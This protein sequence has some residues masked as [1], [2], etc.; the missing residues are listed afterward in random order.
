MVIPA[1]AHRLSHAEPS[2]VVLI[3]T[4]YYGS[5]RKA[6][7][8]FLAE[9]FAALGWHVTFM[10]VGISPISGLRGDLRLRY[11][12]RAEANRVITKA[13]GIDS[14]VWYT[15]WHPFHLR[16]PLLDTLSAPLAR[17]YAALP[18]HGA[19]SFLDKAKV[20]IF[21]STTGLLLFDRVR[22]TAPPA[23]LIYRISDDTRNLGLHGSVIA[24]EERAAPHF[25]LI[26][27]PS[28][29]A[30]MRF[31]HLPQTFWQPHGLD[32]SVFDQP[33]PSPFAPSATKSPRPVRAISVGSSFFDADFIVQAA[34][35]FP[36]WEF[37]ILGNTPP[38]PPLANIIAHGEL[39]FAETVPYFQH[40]DIGLAPYIYRPGAETLADS[41]LKLLQYTY[42]RLP[43]VT[44]HFATRLDRPHI[45]GYRPGDGA[46]IRQALAAALAFNR[47]QVPKS[48]AR[49][50]TFVV[51]EMVRKAEG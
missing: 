3:S 34:T 48:A 32:A 21:E 17:H 2:N 6:G 49:P 4:H 44:P 46:S 31:S 19:E 1:A 16:H 12:V 30:A 37:H 23:R 40:A 13:A 41:S 43:A 51:Q 39:P 33:R 45:F 26:S 15:P 29:H 27:A 35:A 38:L 14:F 11:P 8:H 36:H 28:R 18:W 22:E 20:I 47:A 24:A 42:C 25:H 50:W 7:F 9:A 10:T 5:K